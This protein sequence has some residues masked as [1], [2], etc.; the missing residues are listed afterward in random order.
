[1]AAVIEVN[2]LSKSFVIPSVRRETVREHALDF[3]RARP[4]ERL[5]VSRQHLDMMKEDSITFEEGEFHLVSGGSGFYLATAE[6]G[7]LNFARAA[8]AKTGAFERV[9][10][11]GLLDYIHGVRLDQANALLTQTDLPIKSIA[12]SVG[13]ASRSHFS[14]AFRKH[15]GQDPTSFRKDVAEAIA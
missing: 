3:F 7:L 2:G 8:R 15:R 9:F 5:R 12:A 13:F 10:G 1:M 14:R 6:V 11:E 4:T